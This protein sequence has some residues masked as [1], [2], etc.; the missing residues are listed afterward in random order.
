M[1]LVP[2]DTGQSPYQQDERPPERTG[3]ARQRQMA[4]QSR[5]V[6]DRRRFEASRQVGRFEV[7]ESATG[8]VNA[9]GD[10]ARAGWGRF[11][12]QTLRGQAT[13]IV[14]VLV[15]LVALFSL[16]SLNASGDILPGV[17]V[18]GIR[19]AGLSADAAVIELLERWDERELV[20]RDGD[21]TWTIAPSEIG[22]HL[23]AAASAQQAIAYGRDG[24]LGGL[25]GTAL[26]GVD[27]AP[28]VDIDSTVAR[29]ALSQYA[30]E[31]YVAP[32]NATLQV[33]DALVTHV[34]AE[35]GRRLKI[36]E[37]LPALVVDPL[38]VVE[39]VVIDL[40]MEDVAAYVIDAAPLVS[41]AQALLER[42]LMLEAYDPVADQVHPFTLQPGD[43]GQWLDTR[44]VFHETGPRLYLSVAAAPVRSYLA[45]QADNLPE[46]LTL[47][48]GDGVRA[49]QE[50]IADGTLETW[51]T[52]RYK[53]VD[54]TVGRGETAYSISRTQGIPYYLI[55]QANPERD[56]SELYVGDVVS[57]P[58]RDQMLPFRPLRNKR[59]VVDLSE[60]YLWAYEN[61][62]VLYEWPISSGI[63]SA[64]TSTGVF[65]ILSHVDEASGSSFTLCDEDTCGRWVM[66]WFMGVYEAVPG[67]MNGFHGAVELPN[68]QYLGGGNVGQPY[69]FGCIMSM[70][71]NALTLYNWAEEGVVVEIRQ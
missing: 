38:G 33:Q 3:R 30:S 68:G 8:I 48:L 59:I 42:P 26:R 32:R 36:N 6:H 46:P 27:L 13:L 19:V 21:R 10:A 14:V 31:V 58:S 7:P 56:L 71:E 51:V 63:S 25:I 53:P 16:L 54:Y 35:P 50:S 12:R 39:Q 17:S 11:A 23:D 44:L 2:P 5:R 37:L 67:L 43:W 52:V 69:T 49:V 62:Q 55:E 47:D 40:P 9:L 28:V 18:G 70:E 29:D 15:A 64:P 66:H 22:I 41:Y 60:Q 34:N 20:L 57:L 1:S 61:G 24:G 4:R 45:E 65:Q